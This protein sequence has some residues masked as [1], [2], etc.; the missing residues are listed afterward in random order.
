MARRGKARHGKA[1]HGMAWQ[2]KAGN[3]QKGNTM[4]VRIEVT[5]T[6]PLLMHNEQL[7]IADNKFTKMIK[8]ITDKGTN[9]TTQDKENV[10]KMEWYG[11]LYTDDDGNVVMPAR[12]LI[13]CLIEAATIT[14]SGK[15]IS[16]GISPI[17]LHA[18]FMN[19]GAPRHKDKLWEMQNNI[20][21][22]YRPVKIGRSK[23]MR[24]RPIFNIPWGFSQDFELL[25]DVLSF[26]ELVRI[27]TLA[28]LS[29]GLCDARILG[30]GR[31]TA[32]IA[33]VK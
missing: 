14:K 28:G 21:V 7:S 10:K 27:A 9:Q 22:D 3:F 4:R 30:Y 2:G 24:A 20:R 25:E 32:K 31:F 8:E 17:G 5:G 13:K 19:G 29:K 18:P 23:V 6:T 33:K 26:E 15:K 16:G 11:G 12:N 1:R